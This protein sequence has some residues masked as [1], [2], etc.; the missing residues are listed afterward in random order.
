MGIIYFN[1]Q[2][3]YT[4][5]GG[6]PA[7][8][9]LLTYAQST[10]YNAYTSKQL[11]KKLCIN[12][13]PQ[14]LFLNKS[15]HFGLDNKIYPKYKTEEPQSYIKNTSFFTYGVG[16]RAKAVYIKALSARKLNS[17]EDRI[18]RNYF[19]KVSDNPFLK[20]DD[21]F[22]YFPLEASG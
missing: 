21:N 16:A 13:I 3:I 7:A 4:R 5:A 2:E 12:H 22:I 18:P 8:I 19:N 10:E 11:M 15:L 1:Y 9:L 6:D 17:K 14:R 20:V